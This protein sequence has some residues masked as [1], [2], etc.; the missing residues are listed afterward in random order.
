[1]KSMTSCQRLAAAFRCQE[2]DRVPIQVRGV[3]TI[4]R[5]LIKRHESFRPLVEAV[6]QHGDLTQSWGASCAFLTR[7]IN[8]TN[9]FTRVEK[10]NEDFNV[11]YHTIR[12]PKGDLTCSTNVSTKGHPPMRETFYVKSLEDVEKFLSI[13]YAPHRPDCAP[14]FKQVEALG[15]QGIV[16]ASPGSDAITYVHELLGSELLAIWSIEE[17]ETIHRLLRVFN[18]RLCDTAKYLVS[19]KVGPLFSSS[20]QEYVAPPLHPPKD[21]YDFVVKYDKEVFAILR[22]AG[23]M[24]HVHCHGPIRDLQDGFLEMNINCLHP[25]EA[26]PMGNLPL[27]EAKAKMGHKICLEG[28]IQIGDMYSCTPQEIEQTTIAAIRAAGRGGGLIICPTASPYTPT[29]P[30]VALQNYLAMIRTAR[31]YG[32]YPL[33]V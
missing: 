29:L 3:D 20:G 33:R 5:A 9:T 17:R 1:M 4:S 21:F 25:I 23:G 32:T 8:S 28:N 12:T 18:E 27:A 31:E 15:E 10:R 30:D 6:A 26:P 2:P 7:W 22:D 11:H 24:I 13:P 16:L 19:Q 14:F